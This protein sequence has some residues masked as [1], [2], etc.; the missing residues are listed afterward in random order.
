MKKSFIFA[1]IHFLLSFFNDILF[2]DFANLV[3]PNYIFTKIILYFILLI[4]YHYLFKLLK[5]KDCKEIIT[6][7]AI[8]FIPLM[9]LFISI[10]PGIWYSDDFNFLRMA[11]TCDFMYYLHYLTSLFYSLSL[12]LIPIAPGVEIIQ[13]ICYCMVVTY[14]IY[15]LVKIFKIKGLYKY[16][17][18]IIFIL[19]LT[20][21]Y[22]MYANRPCIYGI[23]YLL[24]FA[25][26]FFNIYNKKHLSKTSMVILLAF[27]SVLAMWRSEGIYLLVF[28]PLLILS[29][30]N[31]KNFKTYLKLF[32]V[33]FICYFI[34]ALPQNINTKYKDKN[35]GFNRFVPS[36]INPL[37]WMIDNGATTNDPRDLENINKVIDVYDMLEYPV[38]NDTPCAWLNG[39]IKDGYT[40][41]DIANFKKSYLNYIL[42]N[43]GLFIEAR[44]KTFLMAT[45]IH[46]S[47]FITHDI[48]ELTGDP[49]IGFLENNKNVDMLNPKLRE[50]MTSLLEG[51]SLHS[52]DP[53]T[54]YCII[55]NLIIPLMTLFISMIVFL[56]LKKYSLSLLCLLPLIHTAIIALTAPASF[57]MYYYP[58]Y[59]VGYFILL[60]D[61][62]WIIK[63]GVKI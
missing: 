27:S 3:I 22:A 55:N 29:L 37:G 41:E 57:I 34:I 43:K 61:I 20:L 62:V 26:I 33:S 48:F 19:P 35:Y 6:Y 7:F 13:I 56:Y 52:H 12:M 60:V 21:F 23:F 40:D 10:Y 53:L 47:T 5:H 38:L 36:F 58:V 14:I 46:N 28:G 18:Y 63:K 16:L 30:A 31:K 44:I 8:I 51:R 15:N 32:I 4:G 59:L 49:I 42:Q 39:C 50:Y 1:I 11:H 24:F 25:I 54:T 17:L 2:L 9:L 45:G